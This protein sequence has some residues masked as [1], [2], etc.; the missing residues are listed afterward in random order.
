M[1]DFLS[2]GSEK[3]AL[4]QNHNAPFLFFNKQPLQPV[5]DLVELLAKSDSV[6]L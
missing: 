2:Y 1:S 6:A 3:G 5:Y 4:R